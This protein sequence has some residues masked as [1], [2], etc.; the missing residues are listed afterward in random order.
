[1]EGT[2]ALFAQVI[3]ANLVQRPPPINSMSKGL[4]T[5]FLILLQSI[6]FGWQQ[7]CPD[8]HLAEPAGGRMTQ[9]HIFPTAPYRS[10]RNMV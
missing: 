8:C 6:R 1:M 9:D 2:D 5:L 7:P 3:T 4:G 10:T